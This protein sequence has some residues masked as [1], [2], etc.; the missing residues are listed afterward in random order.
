M[1]VGFR[2][3]IARARARER[4]GWRKVPAPGVVAHWIFQV[5]RRV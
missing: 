5:E 2:I 4:R 1:L 3:I